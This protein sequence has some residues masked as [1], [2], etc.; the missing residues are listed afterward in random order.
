MGYKVKSILVKKIR[1]ELEGNI[2]RLALLYFVMLIRSIL[3]I[4][5]GYIFSETIGGFQCCIVLFYFTPREHFR[6]TCLSISVGLRAD[7]SPQVIWILC[8]HGRS[9]SSANPLGDVLI[10]QHRES[11]MCSV[12]RKCALYLWIQSITEQYWAAASEQGN[13]KHEI[14]HLYFSDFTPA[15]SNLPHQLDSF[16]VH[17]WGGDAE[18]KN[19]CPGLSGD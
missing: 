12:H 2:I 1:L 17:P 11:F 19:I 10:A 16:T 13:Y 5:Y 3:Q 14:S 4:E 7:I 9:T 15:P 8:V 18:Q 6:K